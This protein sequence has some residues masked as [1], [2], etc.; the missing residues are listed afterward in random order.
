MSWIRFAAASAL[1]FSF[2]FAAPA[3]AEDPDKGARKE[4]REARRELRE[5]L[6]DGGH[7]AT[8]AKDAR[9]R[10]RESREKLRA[11]RDERRKARRA[12]LRAK[13]GDIMARPAVRSELRLH[14]QRMARLHRMERIATARGK[15]D[16]ERRV[17]ALVTR[18]NARHDKRMGELK[19]SVG[20]DK[21]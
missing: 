7:G 15:E 5:A 18:E 4:L 11:S 20:E 14:A 1:A 21:K 12:E 9:E 3:S 13:Y 6:K 2:T 17:Q 10:L 8:A 16:A 19:G